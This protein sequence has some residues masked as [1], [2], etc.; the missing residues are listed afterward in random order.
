MHHSP[1][2]SDPRPRPTLAFIGLASGQ[3]PAP[4]L[5][6]L[7]AHA[8]AHARAACLDCLPVSRP[9]RAAFSSLAARL[10]TL[11]SKPYYA[12]PA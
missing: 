10:C 1:R 2:L 4:N 8:H 9:G 6:F 12:L 3:L 11:V 7:S 5:V